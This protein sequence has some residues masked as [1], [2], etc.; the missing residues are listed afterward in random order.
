[1]KKSISIIILL[2][3][4]FYTFGQS[5]NLDKGLILYF[6]L[7]G[8]FEDFSKNRN[9]G[10]P[11]GKFDEHPD[12]L[13]NSSSSFLFKGSSY[14]KVKDFETPKHITI[15]AWIKTS[16]RKIDIFTK[17][18]Y[19]D[20]NRQK[21]FIFF[22]HAN[23]LLTFAASTNGTNWV[24]TRAPET[25]S[26]NKWHH[27]VATYDGAKI[28]I[29]IDGYFQSEEELN[30]DLT[31][32]DWDAY[33]GVRKQSNDS[34]NYFRGGI[35]ELRVY[36]RALN[37]KEIQE[38]YKLSDESVIT[39]TITSPDISRGFKVIEKNN[40]ITISGNVRANNGIRELTID[41]EPVE[42]DEN[43]NFSKKIKLK[44]GENQIYI[45]AIDWQDNT[46]VQKLVI[47]HNSANKETIKKEDNKDSRSQQKE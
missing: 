40:E 2:I 3:A 14:F 35:D 37:E 32:Y 26:D 4:S 13:G 15:S 39:I 23:G 43:G 34:F 10:I 41:Q 47:T 16:E 7:N 28:K 5:V 45:F 42:L 25:V 20:N 44:E 27:V 8:N 30:G 1:M 33:C 21:G 24:Q 18:K 17:H 38:L 29:Y 6:P 12:R 11:F 36:D 31:N 46:A 19:I 9:D 22:I